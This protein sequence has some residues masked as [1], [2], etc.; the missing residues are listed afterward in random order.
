MANFRSARSKI[1]KV[2]TQV[3]EQHT[4]SILKERSS[5]RRFHLVGVPDDERTREFAAIASLGLKHVPFPSYCPARQNV[6]RGVDDLL[7]RLQIKFPSLT[8]QTRKR[9]RDKQTTPANSSSDLESQRNSISNF[10]EDPN[11][12]ERRAAICMDNKLTPTPW[13]KPMLTRAIPSFLDFAKELK[14]EISEHYSGKKRFLSPEQLRIH[15]TIKEVKAREGWVIKP[16]DKNLGIAIMDA[17]I[18]KNMMAEHLNNEYSYEFL[19]EDDVICTFRNIVCDL[20]QIIYEEELTNSSVALGIHFDELWYHLKGLL[21]KFDVFGIN[22]DVTFDYT[23]TLYVIPKLHKRWTTMPS[24]RPI[25]QGFSGIQNGTNIY[26]SALMTPLLNLC[27]CIVTDINIFREYIQKFSFDATEEHFIAAA[28]VE[29][30]YPNVP[31]SCI[32]ATLEKFFEFIRQHQ[33]SDLVMKNC[34]WISDDAAVNF[35]IKISIWGINGVIIRVPREDGSL[36]VTRSE[37]EVRFDCYRQRTGLPMGY[38]LSPLLAN[39]VLF[40][41]IELPQFET[42]LV[43]FTLYARYLDDVLLIGKTSEFNSAV[44]LNAYLK[45]TFTDRL[46]TIRLISEWSK[47]SVTFLDM[48]CCL[49]PGRLTTKGYAKPSSTFPYVRLDSKHPRHVHKAILAAEIRRQLRLNS[50]SADFRNMIPEIYSRFLNR[51]YGYRM[52]RKT[53]RVIYKQ[54]RANRTTAFDNAQREPEFT[55]TSSCQIN[56]FM[57]RVTADDDRTTL[58]KSFSRYHVQDK[59]LV[60]LRIEYHPDIYEDLPTNIIRR[61]LST[62]GERYVAQDPIRCLPLADSITNAWILNK[63][64]QMWIVSA[65]RVTKEASTNQADRYDTCAKRKVE[66]DTGTATKRHRR[67]ETDTVDATLEGVVRL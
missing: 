46:E 17:C 44:E 34:P 5:I 49:G 63:N 1:V 43:K 25:V 4:I 26:L 32:R 40:T 37:A 35:I 24:G 33:Y 57:N 62:V 11:F 30:L 41:L 9:F 61:V 19:S 51:G 45:M 13:K 23:C 38:A 21:C 50:A 16:S 64:L 66:E 28:D 65:N 14:A 52:I 36:M 56:R 8:K 2:A 31:L 47:E 39:L 3:L 42:H 58:E 18:Y 54:E 12:F 59:G 7:W 53:L 15:R 10:L 48:I 22:L 55:E 6:S 67:S 60:P 20:E 27:S 29:A